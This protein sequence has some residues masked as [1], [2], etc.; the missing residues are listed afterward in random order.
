MRLTI[1]AEQ[2]GSTIVAQAIALCQARSFLK[3]TMPILE[4]IVYKDSNSNS[5]LKKGYFFLSFRTLNQRV[6]KANLRSW[7]ANANSLE[8]EEET[9]L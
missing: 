4:S 7:N 1:G 3:V 2:L 8:L 5:N 9:N 6:Q